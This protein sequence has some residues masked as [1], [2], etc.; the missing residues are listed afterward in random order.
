MCYTGIAGVYLNNRILGGF[1]GGEVLLNLFVGQNLHYMPALHT[2]P[3][4]KSQHCLQV[5][6]VPPD[7]RELVPAVDTFKIDS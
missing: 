2:F 7:Y 1:Q 4:R 5:L 6:S 3:H